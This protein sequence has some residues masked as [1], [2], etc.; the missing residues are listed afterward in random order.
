M[1]QC[2]LSLN[3]ALAGLGP[4]GKLRRQWHL[5]YALLQLTFSQLTVSQLLPLIGGPRYA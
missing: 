2:I 1:G 4:K 3:G 5:L